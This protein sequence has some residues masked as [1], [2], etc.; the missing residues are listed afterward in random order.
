MKNAVQIEISRLTMEI[1][2]ANFKIQRLVEEENSN[3]LKYN[4]LQT[5]MK[6]VN[7]ELLEARLA[8]DVKNE[9]LNSF[10]NATFENNE[11]FNKKIEEL[12]Q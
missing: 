8:L 3:L 5:K 6:D 2:E 11:V 7:N 9:E 12:Q 4:K 10:K 1:I